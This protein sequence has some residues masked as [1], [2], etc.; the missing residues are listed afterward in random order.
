MPSPRRRPKVQVQKAD[1]G[2]AGR[3]QMV[4]DRIELESR[5]ARLG[6]MGSG[7]PNPEWIRDLRRRYRIPEAYELPAPSGVGE[8]TDR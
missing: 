6:T 8:G 3:A 5:L 4:A 7:L 1:A 2:L